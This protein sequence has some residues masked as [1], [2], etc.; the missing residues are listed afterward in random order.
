MDIDIFKLLMLFDAV[1]LLLRIYIKE[2]TLSKNLKELP[3]CI[4]ITCCAVLSPS[5]LS[6]SYVTLWTVPYQAPLSMGFSRQEYWS[7]LPCPPPGDLPNPGI[8]ASFH[9]AGGFFTD[10]DSR[11]AQELLEWVAYPFS[12]GLSRP[13]N[14]TRA[15]NQTRHFHHDKCKKV[16]SNL[17]FCFFFFGCAVRPV[18][19]KFP[20]QGLNPGHS[21]ESTEFYTLDHQGTPRS[22]LDV[23]LYGN[24]WVNHRTPSAW[25]IIPPFKKDYRN[26]EKC[27]W[28]Y[29]KTDQ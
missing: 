6:D 11:D 1:I 13:R 19:S 14:W 20:K 26:T 9:M 29:M 2:I 12:R 5:V 28:R 3:T 22:K 21:S 24:N 25:N 18:G 4:L 23:H 16:T 27:L 8:E 15:R 17:P 10:W 7:G